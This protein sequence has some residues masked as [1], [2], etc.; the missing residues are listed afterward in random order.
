[1]IASQQRC[2]GAVR[3]QSAHG[4]GI[5]DA[6]SVRLGNERP[7]VDDACRLDTL[8]AEIVRYLREN[9]RA[10]DTLDGIHDWWLRD[11]RL[12][13]PRE[14]TQQAVDL[15]VARGLLSRVQLAGSV[16]VYSVADENAL[17]KE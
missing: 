9:P 4:P 10:A 3:R 14:V 15:L 11:A 16:W 7:N 2:R 5:G 13:C 8:L 6:R 12:H 1:M 17:P